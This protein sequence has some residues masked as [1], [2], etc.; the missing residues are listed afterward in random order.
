MFTALCSIFFFFFIVNCKLKEGSYVADRY[1][2]DAYGTAPLLADVAVLLL[3]YLSKSFGSQFPEWWDETIQDERP[4]KKRGNDERRWDHTS[5]V[6]MQI[7]Y[8]KKKVPNQ[9]SCRLLLMV[10]PDDGAHHK[11]TQHKRL[12]P[13]PWLYYVRSTHHIS[14]LGT[15]TRLELKML[16]NRGK[17]NMRVGKRKKW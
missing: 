9:T 13:P 11:R 3:L 7:C 12:H 6:N 17:W 4:K 5:Y 8:R 15:P 16:R 10:N 1:L 2:W 14:F